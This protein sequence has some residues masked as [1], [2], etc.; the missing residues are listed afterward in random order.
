MI[1][2]GH[3][4]TPVGLGRR[5]FSLLEIYM[6][7]IDEAFD[8]ERIKKY[9]LKSNSEG[10]E[11]EAKI[12]DEIV[13]IYIYVEQANL[14]RFKLT[15]K[16]KSEA[17]PDASVYNFGFEIG[18]NRK[19]DQYAKT[20]YKDYIKILATVG[21]A[22]TKL[23]SSKHPDYVTFFSESKHGGIVSDT[24]KDDVYFKAIDK[25]KP[26]NYELTTIVDGVDGK[27]GLMLYRKK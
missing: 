6:E 7:I 24:Q 26:S 23:I 15:P 3:Y 1:N 27:F 25:N 22:L 19:N 12:N 10:W 20:T 9:P 18:E 16:M 21:T 11:F 8:F 13:T 14:N 4:D 17:P 5:R 2:K